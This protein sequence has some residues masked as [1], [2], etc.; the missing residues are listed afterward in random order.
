[1]YSC[2]FFK[3]K[4]S[5]IDT[6][7]YLSDDKVIK[8][9]LKF[10]ANWEERASG[11]K[12]EKADQYYIPRRFSFLLKAQTRMKKNTNTRTKRKKNEANRRLPID[13]IPWGLVFVSAIQSHLLSWVSFF[14]FFVLSHCLACSSWETFG[15]VRLTCLLC[16]QPASFS[17]DFSCYA[18]LCFYGGHF[19]RLNLLTL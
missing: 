13:G 3:F 5:S 2:Y 19:W 14:L 17:L 16:M 11:H 10:S 6:Q 15:E 9:A 18:D 7:V 4:L 1:M 12:D 8:R